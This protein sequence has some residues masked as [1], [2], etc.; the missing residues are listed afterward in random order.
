MVWYSHPFKNFP[1]F[2]VI[3]IVRSFSVVNEA[4]FF[5]SFVCLFL[6]ISRFFCDPTD[7]GN[8][9]SGSSAFLNPACTSGS[10]P[11]T[12]YGSLAWRILSIT[13]LACEMSAI[14]Q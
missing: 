13:L 5:F 9:M 1:H 14:E 6:E 10:S 8:L 2:A 3:H 4:D 7:V 11:F 12:Y